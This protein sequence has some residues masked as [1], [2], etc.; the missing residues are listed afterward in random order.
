MQEEMMAWTEWDVGPCLSSSREIRSWKS[1]VYNIKLTL[2][3]FLARLKARL[4]DKGYSQMYGIDYQEISRVVKLTF[5]RLLISFVATHHCHYINLILRMLSF[6]V[7]LMKKF[8]W[9][10]LLILLLKRSLDNFIIS[11]SF[12]IGWSILLG[13]D[14]IY[15]PQLFKSLGFVFLRMIILFSF[16]S[17]EN[18]ILLLIFMVDIVITG[19]DT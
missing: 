1:W 15:L 18:W 4:V 5:V 9:S 6:M 17:M 12:Y 14:L 13:H 3:G 10:N 2:Y 8:I 19:D 11:E 7:S 16:D